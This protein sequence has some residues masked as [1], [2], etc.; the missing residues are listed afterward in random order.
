[1]NSLDRDAY[2]KEEQGKDGVSIRWPE[3]ASL[4]Q[5]QLSQACGG[6]GEEYSRKEWKGRPQAEHELGNIQGAEVQCGENE[7]GESEMR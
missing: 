2:S 5:C 7:D 1:M 6:P 4:R 3:K